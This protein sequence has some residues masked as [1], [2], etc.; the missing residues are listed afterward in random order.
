L[1]THLLAL[2]ALFFLL[3]TV[4]CQKKPTASFSTDKEVY[5]TRET[6]YLENSSTEA[7]Y[8]TW[9]VKGPEKEEI[10]SSKED[11]SFTLSQVGTYEISLS[12][13]SK[14]G[15]LV[16]QHSKSINSQNVKA[17]IGRVVFYTTNTNTIYY[18]SQN[19]ISLGYFEDSFTG[20]PQCNATG[21]LTCQTAAGV[22]SFYIQKYTSV[23]TDIAT[24]TVQVEDGLCKPLLVN[25]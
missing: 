4:S 23:T 11:F 18:V 25:F 5:T 1:K 3:T 16:S 22:Q 10:R 13:Y 21:A 19:G 8:Y 9:I 20:V 14:N 24:Y 17:N 6:V 7:H 12:V 15:K 2:T